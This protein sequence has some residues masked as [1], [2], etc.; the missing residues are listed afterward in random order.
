MAFG[1]LTDGELREAVKEFR[2]IVRQMISA[3][4]QTWPNRLLKCF[5]RVVESHRNLA[6]WYRE[7]KERE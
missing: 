4:A 7:Q 1:V 3:G 6:A 2:A 5:N